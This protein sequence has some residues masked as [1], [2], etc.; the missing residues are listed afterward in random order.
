MRRLQRLA[1]AA[2]LAW[3]WLPA[4]CGQPAPSAP[5]PAP[6]VKLKLLQAP[7]A[8]LEGW[9]GLSG[10]L[11]VLEFWATWCDACV[12][13]QPRLNELAARFQGR[14]VQFLSVTSD[15]EPEVRRFLKR[16]PL[17]GWIGLD[18]DGAASEA[19]GVRGLPRTVILNA[20]GE[21]LGETYPELLSAE[22]L[23]ALLA[24]AP[25]GRS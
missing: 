17:R 5:R 10:K 12:E 24:A 11:V 15:P 14:P 19:F 9:S 7:L 16:H 23:E 22:R 2:V 3:A 1:A 21:I 13:E 20:R 4:G 25:A 18:P 8:E 6:A